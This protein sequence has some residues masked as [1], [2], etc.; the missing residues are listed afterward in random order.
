MISASNS[1]SSAAAFCARLARRLRP[2]RQRVQRHRRLQLRERRALALLTFLLLQQPALLT[3]Q[4]LDAR[5]FD[6]RLALTQGHR[7]GVRRPR[8]AA[9]PPAPA[10][11][12][13]SACE[14]RRSSRR[15]RIEP[16]HHGG[17][18][19]ATAI[20]AGCGRVADHA[21]RVRNLR[22]DLFQV[23]ALP[24]AQLARVLDAL[25]RSA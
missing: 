9:T 7:L 24:L 8:T 13:S 14:A 3:F 20:R 11:S 12:R 18:F 1:C 6:L 4:L 2:L 17:Q 23:G 5:A 16:G 15:A 10:R 22:L 19:R 21:G 25:V